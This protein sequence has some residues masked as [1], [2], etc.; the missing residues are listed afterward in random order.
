MYKE[1]DARAELLFHQSKPI[2]FLT[3]SLKLVEVT[4]AVAWAPH[5][6]PCME[7]N[8]EDKARTS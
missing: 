2:A 4:V 3:F 1:R 7:D 8:C 5:S 6:R